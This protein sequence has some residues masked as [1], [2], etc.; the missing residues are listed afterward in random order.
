[1]SVGRIAGTGIAGIALLVAVILAL[2]IHV[3]T[4]VI[5]F[6]ETGLF[7][8]ALTLVFPIFSEV[9]WFIRVW[10][11]LGID[12]MYC[13]AILAYLGLWIVGSIAFAL[14]PSK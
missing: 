4:I 10:H 7:G 8:G 11:A 14:T 5:A 1:M 6:S 2:V 13:V 9:Y 3:W 12:S